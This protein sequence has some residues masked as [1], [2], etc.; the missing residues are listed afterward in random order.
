MSTTYF[1]L[2]RAEWRERQSTGDKFLYLS[3]IFGAKPQS[4]HL[5]LREELVALHESDNK[6]PVGVDQ[7]YSWSVKTHEYTDPQTGVTK[8][9]SSVEFTPVS[10]ETRDFLLSIGQLQLTNKD[11]EV[12]APQ[13]LS[14]GATQQKSSTPQEEDN[15][16]V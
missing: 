2:A 12:P 8:L 3:P 15:F 5:Y 4:M 1:L 14:E 7:L 6:F 13:V 9:Y 16:P 11:I 10:T